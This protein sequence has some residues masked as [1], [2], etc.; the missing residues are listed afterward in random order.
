LLE[1]EEKVSRLNTK[2]D[3]QDKLIKE[4]EEERISKLREL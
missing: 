2:I 3:L 4:K 1:Y